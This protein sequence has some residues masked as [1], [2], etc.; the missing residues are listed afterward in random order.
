M[1][2]NVLVVE[3]EPDV[4]FLLTRKF[5]ERIRTNELH[6][7]FTDNGVEALKQLETNPDIYVVLSD[8]NMPQMDGLTLLQHLNER[9]PLIRTVII[10][11]YG[12][13]KNIRTAM[14]LGAYDFLTKPINFDDLEAT[15]NKTIRHVQ[16]L[17]Y[18]VNKRKHAENQLLELK[19]AVETM[20]LG[21]TITDLDGQI[22][23]VNPAE[24]RMHGY[25]VDQLAGQ[26]VSLFAPAER[27]ETMP[28]EQIKQWGGSIRE[29]ENIR[30]DG[31]T[32]PVWLISDLVKN[33]DGEPTTIVTS[34]EDITERKKAEEELRRHRD[35]LEELIKE[36]TA[37]LMTA[38]EQLRQ[39]VTERKQTED[40]LQKRNRELTLIN[41]VGKMFGSTIDLDR[42][43][44]SVLRSVRHLLNISSTSCWL[45]IPETGELVCQQAIGPGSELMIGWRLAPGQ[46]I[47]GHVAQVG[48]PLIVGDS[49]N[50]PRHYA[51]ADQKTGVELRSLLSIPFQLKGKTIGVLTSGDTEVNRFIEDDLRL[52]EPIATTA[53]TAIENARLYKQAQQEITERKK[54]EEALRESEEKYRVLFENLQD[55][56]YR[57][58]RSGNILLVS[59]SIAQLLGYTVEE[60]L[61]LNLARDIFAY[62]EQWDDFMTMLN[63]DGALQNVEVLLKRTDGSLEWGSVSARFYTDKEGQVL[64]AEGIIRDISV[65]KQAEVELIAAHNELQKT[66]TQLQELN[67]SKDKF[68]SIISH[69]LRSAF[70][71]LLGFTELIVEHFDVYSPEK[72]KNLV[73]K[74]KNSAE[75]LYALLENLLTWSR[76]Q[77]GAM[78]C[79]AEVIDLFEITTENMMIFT[80]KA[81]QKGILL[82]NLIQD[83]LSAYAD[84]SMVNTVLRNLIS[85]ALKFTET[86]GTIT[87]S[88]VQHDE[89]IEVAVADTG[90]GI[91]E[92][93]MDMLFR[94]DTS[95]SN[96]GTDG[97]QG[98]GLG[99]ILCKELVEQNG[100]KIWVESEVG[101]GTIFRFTLPR[102]EA[103]NHETNSQENL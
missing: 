47:T 66:N 101:K 84:Y 8:I 12:D 2:V 3:D 71:T 69:D 99:L 27:R 11:A 63:G 85:N 22:V 53:A 102:Q 20:R 9:Y 70:S 39:E 78:K 34:C 35:H 65:R 64:G 24:A 33:V 16:Q 4:V 26:H 91:D 42:V 94:I 38:N 74:V 92:Y 51:D 59:P 55:V 60:V 97:E 10:S 28:L 58:D 54:A 83:H 98:T 32:F 52:I 41:Q 86:G 25:Q 79:Q 76:I 46:G 21:V 40:L 50:D 61:A 5:R 19:K 6:F 103:N 82:H 37:E 73:Y 95:Y 13:M 89:K 100:G 57:V 23:Y 43:L 81:E 77:R 15:L 68:F 96:V 18:E 80:S 7:L 45:C 17:L 14:N 56:F 75:K 62:P 88:G 1:P 48:Q 31:S 87:V 67:A 49:R 29:S 30:K 90:C 72:I 93:G 44:A 36:R